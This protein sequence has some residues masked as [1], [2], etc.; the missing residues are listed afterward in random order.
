MKETTDVVSIILAAGKGTRMEGYDGNKTLLPL[1]PGPSPYQGSRPM[2]LHILSCLPPGPKAL[3]IHHG[4]ESIIEATGGL[5]LAYCF[6]PVLNG[7]GGALLSARGFI[8]ELN[9]SRIIIT[10]GDV[11]LVKRSTYLDLVKGLEEADLMILGF[12]PKDKRQYGVLEIEGNRVTRIVEWE[13]WHKYSYEHQ[14]TLKTCNS[15][16]YA[17]RRDVLLRYLRLLEARPHRVRKEREGT[18]LEIQEFFVTDLVELMARDG[19]SV[20]YVLAHDE[21]EV[22]GVDDLHALKEVQE[23]YRTLN[24]GE[25]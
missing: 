20:H 3:V 23:L 6:Q 22:M 10:M 21:R 17:A 13:Y 16:I 4:K 1:V 25:P 19:L 8:Q 9:L 24:G 2:L 12:Q 11:P 15:G 18:I 14:E 5:D 7:T